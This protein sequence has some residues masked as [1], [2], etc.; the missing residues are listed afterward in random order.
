M[1]NDMNR[2]RSNIG[3]QVV[4]QECSCKYAA[5]SA[6]ILLHRPKRPTEINVKNYLLI[7]LAVVL[8]L[9]ACGNGNNGPVPT[10]SFDVQFALPSSIDVSEGSEYT[11]SDFGQK[12]ITCVISLGYHTLEGLAKNL[13]L[14]H[15]FTF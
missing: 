5:N 14:Y 9:Y 3:K 10:N 1:R 7:V 2:I 4:R 13:L 6:V 11:F 15:N 12:F 8:Q